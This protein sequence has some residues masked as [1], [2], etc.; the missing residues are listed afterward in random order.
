MLRMRLP[1]S[2]RFEEL[3]EALERRVAVPAERNQ[4]RPQDVL[5]ADEGEGHT[6]FHRCKP[7][8]ED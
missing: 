4:A 5:A 8:K 6:V 1:L 2:L 3:L 7:G